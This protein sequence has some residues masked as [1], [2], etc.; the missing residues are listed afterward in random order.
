MP[1]FIFSSA[2]GKQMAFQFLSGCVREARCGAA[3]LRLRR[4]AGAG[5]RVPR[6]GVVEVGRRGC[7]SHGGL[8]I[9]P[10]CRRSGRR[11]LGVHDAAA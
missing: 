5:L 2:M 4:E 10:V 9:S 1:A 3:D 7:M 11:L 8:C 6:V